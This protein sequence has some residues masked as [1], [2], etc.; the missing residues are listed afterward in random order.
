MNALAKQK[1]ATNANGYNDAMLAM[2]SKL[3]VEK[4]NKIHQLCSHGATIALQY[5]IVFKEKLKVMYPE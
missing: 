2:L 1:L 3:A 5:T 4:S